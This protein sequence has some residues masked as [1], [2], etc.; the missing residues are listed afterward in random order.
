MEFF[1]GT[2][3]PDWL[4]KTDVPL[5]VSR[6]ALHKRKTFP[7][8]LGRWALDSG[9]FTE[10]SLHGKWTVPTKRY[11]EEVRR[12]RD[13]VG[14]L[15]WASPCDWMCE[16]EMLRRTGKTVAEHQR[17][18]VDNLLELRSLAPDLPFIPVLQGWTRGDYYDCVDLYEKAGIDLCSEPI[19]GIGTV[20]RRQNTLMAQT[21]IRMLSMDGIR[22]HGFGF[23]KQGLKACGDVLASADSMAWSSHGRREPP[24]PGH[25][26]RHKNCANCLEFAL[27]WRSDLLE[28]LQSGRPYS[29]PQLSLYI[30]PQ[31]TL[32][33]PGIVV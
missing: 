23:K 2:H 6:R 18:T 20:C 19:V 5:F 12:F 26:S 16:P 21:T 22:L 29:D 9:G 24:L 32:A 1:L 14:Q 15:A 7:R 10:L 4:G 28:K 27:L 31:L 17:L 3:H 13:S 33:L 30:E 25:A 8:A 11:V